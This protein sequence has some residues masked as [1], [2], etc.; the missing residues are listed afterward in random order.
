VFLGGDERDLREGNL[1]RFDASSGRVPSEILVVALDA[2]HGERGSVESRMSW[3][4]ARRSAVAIRDEFGAEALLVREPEE[5]PDPET[6]AE[7]VNRMDA[8]V[9]LSFH[10]HLRSG[11]AAA[12][13]ARIPDG[14][15]SPPANLRDMGFRPFH[16]AQ[17]PLLPVSR[18]LARNLVQAIAVRTESVPLGVFDEALP[19]LQG[20]QVP[21]VMIEIGIGADGLSEWDLDEIARGA[22]EGLRLFLLSGEGR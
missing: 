19:E 10:L 21:A 9:F 8:D 12:F 18:L 17:E 14:L 11:G 15:P 16:A 5:N 22:V 6:R 2:G 1:R 20:C 3:E 7:R 13:V 4:A